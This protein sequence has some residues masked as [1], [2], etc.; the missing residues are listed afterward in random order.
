MAF[1]GGRGPCGGESEAPGFTRREEGARGEGERKRSAHQVKA[2]SL[3]ALE[4][5]SIPKKGC[6]PGDDK[7]EK[8][9]TL[10]VPEE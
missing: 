9:Q 2:A 8:G 6:L 7:R 1:Q 5:L 10:P 4:V 3:G